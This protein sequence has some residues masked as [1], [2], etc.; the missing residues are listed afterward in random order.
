M[1]ILA[2][3]QGTS[4]TK[5]L[6]IE[7]NKVI[8]RGFCSVQVQHFSEGKVESNP[9]EIWN[10][11]VFAVTSCLDSSEAKSI[12]IHSVSLANQGES[13]LA[14]DSK[15]LEPVS[16][17][18]IWQDSRS[19]NLCQERSKYTSLIRELTGLEND[20]YFVAPKLAWLK[21]LHP[22]NCEI[23]TLDSW[24][25][26]KLT[27]EFITDISTASRSMLTNLETGQWDKEL[28]EIWGLQNHNFPKIINNDAIVGE[29]NSLDLPD[30]KGIPLAGLIVD[31]AA[32]LLAEN[33]LQAGEAKCTYGT[34]AFL[35]TNIGN[36][37][38][39]SQNRL[40]TSIAWKVS[41]S[42]CYY[43][44]GQVFTATSA[45]D[46]LLTNRF[47]H[48][49]N[50]IDSLPLDT[51]GVFALPGFAGYGA[52]RWK[53]NGTASIFGLHLGVTRQELSRA[54][55]NGI[56]T[57]VT[58]LIE[59]IALDGSNIKQMRVDGGLTQSE[60]LMQFQADLAQVE[61]QVFPHPDATA[62]G[63]GVLGQLALD[64]NL[65]LNQ[66]DLEVKFSKNYYPNWSKDKATEYLN[67]WRDKTKNLV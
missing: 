14:W 32:A 20:P 28:I 2:I 49:V 24:L 51:N 4:G 27:G 31:Q 18:L 21:N 67:D 41:D 47:L 45:V 42:F 9:A 10:S 11:I 64:S 60:T 6:L 1:A 59:V 40:S 63:V 56:A 34:G 8:S 58:E 61:I 38:K 25:I 26:A 48:S 66:I 3:D 55:L 33:C 53:P 22:N 37:K 54:V 57:Q 19:A 23:T 30:L 29:I 17:V 65:R 12:Q 15:T 52:P 44:D 62:I 43:E 35:L 39:I 46:W 7:N 36:Q 16:Q 5:A 13:V 50:E